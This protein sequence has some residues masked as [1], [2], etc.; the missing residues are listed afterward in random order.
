MWWL[1]RRPALPADVA[2]K[3]VLTEA[4]AAI[5]KAA[6]AFHGVM[7]LTPQDWDQLGCKTPV[8]LHTPVAVTHCWLQHVVHC[9]ADL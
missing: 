4:S 9:R 7:R 3:L 8:G 1:H 6:A 2:K 5:S